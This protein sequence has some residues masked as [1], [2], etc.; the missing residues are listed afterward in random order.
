MREPSGIASPPRAVW[1]A[2]PVPALVV[3]Q[4]PGGDRLDAERVEHAKADLRMALEDEALGLVQ[5]PGLKDLLGDGELS[6]VVQGAGQ[7]GELDLL[8]LE[9]PSSWPPAPRAPRPCRSA[10]PCRHRGHRPHGPRR[11]PRAACRRSGPR[12]GLKLGQ[13]EQVGAV[14]PDAVLSVLLGEVEGRVGHAH[15]LGALHAVVGVRDDACR[16]AGGRPL[17]RPI[18]PSAISIASRRSS[19]AEAARTRPRRSGMPPVLA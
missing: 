3:V 13:L 15:E 16:R 6:E 12:P 2:V 7:A 9:G 4:D 14:D 17:T 5:G 1:I 18:T 19:R 11:P 10:S 8:G